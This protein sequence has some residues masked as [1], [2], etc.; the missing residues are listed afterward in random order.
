MRNTS[1]AALSTRPR[2]CCRR[3]LRRAPAR[4]GRRLCLRPSKTPS[5]WS[6][7]LCGTR[8]NNMLSRHP[9]ASLARAGADREGARGIFRPNLFLSVFLRDKQIGKRPQFHE[10]IFFHPRV[11]TVARRYFLIF[12]ASAGKTP[13]RMGRKK[14]GSGR[15]EFFLTGN[16]RTFSNNEKN[17]QKNIRLFSAT[18]RWC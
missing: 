12:A 17:N 6:A 2:R 16:T 14:W 15:N 13:G 5:C 18:P 11:R 8:S 1:I 3:H 7:P 9:K 4:G 10:N